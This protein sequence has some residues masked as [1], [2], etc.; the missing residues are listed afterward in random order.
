MMIENTNLLEEKKQR[1]HIMGILTAITLLVQQFMELEIAGRGL[2][3]YVGAVDILVLTLSLLS[4]KI[5]IKK[6]I[7]PLVVFFSFQF[8][9]IM[10]APSTIGFGEIYKLLKIF[11]IY[12]ILALIKYNKRDIKLIKFC[13]VASAIFAALNIMLS[14]NFS[15][16]SE[17]SVYYIFGVAQDP[18]YTNLL[19]I[20]PV[21][22]L[23]DIFQKRRDLFYRVISLTSLCIIFYAVLKTGSRGG[24]ISIIISCSFYLLFYN[25]ITFKR[26]I[27]LC[28]M[29]FIAYQVSLRLILFLP[30]SVAERFTIYS[31]INSGASG[32]T[33]IW[34]M[35]F[36]IIINY[37][38]I[39]RIFFGYGL[40]SSNYYMGAA[41]H[42][43]YIQLLFEFGLLGSLIFSIFMGTNLRKLLLQGNYLSISVLLGL[44]IMAFSLSVNLN[45]Y[46][47]MV[48]GPSMS[49]HYEESHT[50]AHS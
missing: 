32:R 37:S 46:F 42:N 43:Y 49:I 18:N 40:S 23:L 47:W 14:T 45:I 41:A 36:D 19:F 5:T 22:I 4:R 30:E 27:V 33:Y 44:I 7:L 48:L 29:A 16:G 13:I 38:S 2:L 21:I 28:I 15:V 34:N 17:R 12:F 3:L 1:I 35:Y 26:L 8:F 31:A 6:G 24:L 11:M 25:R 9:T 39:G 20:L 10:W 50:K